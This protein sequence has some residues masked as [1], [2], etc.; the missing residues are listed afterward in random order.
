VS[1]NFLNKY[2]TILS[3]QQCNIKRKLKSLIKNIQISST[4]KQQLL[5]SK[6]VL[7]HLSLIHL[8]RII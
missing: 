6:C 1:S 8:I 4:D 5:L 7:L 2:G 3:I